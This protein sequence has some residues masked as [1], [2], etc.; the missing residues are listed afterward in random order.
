MDRCTLDL[1]GPTTINRPPQ[2][3]LFLGAIHVLFSGVLVSTVIA[4]NVTCKNPKVRREWR[5]LSTD[6]RIEWIN[7]IKV[8]VPL[9]QAMCNAD[10]WLLVSDYSSPRSQADTICSNECFVDPTDQRNQLFL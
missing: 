3:R 2:M 1:Y 4:N 10:Q 6:Q 8:R 9:L 7:A 5:K